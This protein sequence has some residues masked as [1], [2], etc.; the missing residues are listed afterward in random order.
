MG[1]HDAADEVALADGDGE[2]AF[3]TRLQ[4]A[5][6]RLFERQGGVGGG[7][8]HA[9]Q[10]PHQEAEECGPPHHRYPRLTVTVRPL[11]AKQLST[12]AHEA[13]YSLSAMLVALSCTRAPSSRRSTSPS[14]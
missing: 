8:P 11:P 9:Q 6:L 14:S 10:R 7:R 3:A 1:L 13:T 4:R 5:A 12:D 2:R